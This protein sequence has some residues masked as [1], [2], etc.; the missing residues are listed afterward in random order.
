MDFEYKGSL[1]NTIEK[2]PESHIQKNISQ[3]KIILYNIVCSTSIILL[4]Y[5]INIFLLYM[6]NEGCFTLIIHQFVL[7]MTQNKSI[8][9]H[10]L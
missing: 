4:I 2:L 5:M 1:V 6:S 8:L 7:F 9:K 10:R 3:M